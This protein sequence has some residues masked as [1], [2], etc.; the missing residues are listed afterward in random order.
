MFGIVA[1]PNPQISVSFWF[2]NCEVFLQFEL[3]YRVI[4]I[5]CLDFSCY[6]RSFSPIEIGNLGRWGIFN[7]VI[8]F[9][10]LWNYEQET[11]SFR[12]FSGNWLIVELCCKLQ[13]FKLVDSECSIN[14]LLSTYL[15]S[16]NHTCTLGTFCFLW[17]SP[18]IS[19]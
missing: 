5:G 12:E 7:I 14:G 6:N 10:I 19:T 8:L 15:I 1:N 17:F 9:S 4:F 11:L 16:F 18:K 13:K 2:V 3:I